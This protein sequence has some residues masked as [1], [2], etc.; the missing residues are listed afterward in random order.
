MSREAYLAYQNRVGEF[1]RK[2]LQAQ[3]ITRQIRWVSTSNGLVTMVGILVIVGIDYAM[4]KQE[5]PQL[6]WISL[7]LTVLLILLDVGLTLRRNHLTSQRVALFREHHLTLNLAP[8]MRNWPSLN[9]W[10]AS[11]VL[12]ELLLL[13]L[14]Y[15]WQINRLLLQIQSF[16]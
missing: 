10:L 11:A 7:V 15:G 1:I 5:A 16:H 8:R 9:N 6:F 2:N 4:F 14:S 3:Q 12:V 13:L